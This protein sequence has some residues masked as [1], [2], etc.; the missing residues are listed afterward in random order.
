MKIRKKD[1]TWK[2]IIYSEEQLY[3]YGLN[4]LS[5]REFGQQELSKKMLRLQPDSEVVMGVIEK[6]VEKGYLSD[7]RRAKS[8]IRMFERDGI[9][10]IER[11]LKEKGILQDVIEIEMLE[12][13]ER[14]SDGTDESDTNKAYDLLVKKFK[15][16]KFE[17]YQKATRFLVS[18][19]FSFDDIKRAIKMLRDNK[20]E[21]DDFFVE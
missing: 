19:G 3:K 10:K 9:Q 16:F 4:R 17:D 18:R 2:E 7:E 6:L 20:E 14:R 1:G 21:S 5:E 12:V 11:K 13:K 8:L 15:D